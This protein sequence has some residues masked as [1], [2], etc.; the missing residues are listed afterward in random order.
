MAKKTN[1]R[2]IRITDEILEVIEAQAGENF[3]Q[4]YEALIRRCIFELPATERRL[5]QLNQEIYEKRQQLGRLSQKAEAFA[6]AL[7]NAE[8]DLQSMSRA[9]AKA[10]EHEPPNW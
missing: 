5:E 4:K 10:Q 3:T 9:I 1:I 6:A 2:S 8:R 7:Q